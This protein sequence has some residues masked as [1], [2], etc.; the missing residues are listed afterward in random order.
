MTEQ[1]RSL[2]HLVV[3]ATTGRVPLGARVALT[4]SPMVL[5]RTAGADIVFPSLY[6][7]RRH[8]RFERREG[9]WWIVDA[10]STGGVYVNDARITEQPLASGDRIHLGDATLVFEPGGVDIPRGAA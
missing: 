9:G 2:P 7:S 4:H 8:C 5:G 3:A 1:R 10:H 6:V